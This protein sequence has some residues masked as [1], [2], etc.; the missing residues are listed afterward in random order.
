MDANKV[1]FWAYEALSGFETLGPRDAAEG[2]ILNLL[3][4]L[5]HVADDP[6]SIALVERIDLRSATNS[7]SVTEADR[8]R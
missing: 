7:L 8:V 5:L 2:A 6:A 3:D 4:I 1:R